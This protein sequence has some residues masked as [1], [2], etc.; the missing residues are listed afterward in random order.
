MI[1]A[2][3]RL[4]YALVAVLLMITACTQQPHP[5]QPKIPQPSGA[6]PPVTAGSTARPVEPV[7]S[8]RPPGM[9]DPPSGHGMS[10][11]TGQKIN[12]R[13]CATHGDR[14]KQ[15]A[16]VLVPLDYAHP[17]GTAITLAI[18][19]TPSTAAH[20]EGSIF[21]NPGGPG[22]SGVD[23]LD[24]FD[25]HGLRA[26]FDIVSWDPRGT[27]NSTPVRCF[28]DQQMDD[29]IGIDYSPDTPREVQR[30]IN[31]N[32]AFGQAC[33]AKSGALLEHL[34]T[35]DT[36]RDLDLLRRLLG[37]PRMNY[38]GFSYGTT[39]GAMY[40]TMYGDRV[41]RM[42]LDGATDVGST[43]TVSQAD[44][45]DRTLG[46]FATW[47]AQ[48]DCR[49]G[50]SKQKVL[51]TVG[52]FLQQLDQHPIAAGQRQLSQ[53]L[54]TSGLLY[55]LYAPASSWP[56]LLKGL[57]LAIYAHNGSVLLSWAYAYYERDGSGHFDQFNAAFPAILCADEP[58][59]GA[60]AELKAWAADEQR[61]R[62]LGQLIGPDLTCATWP[63]KS[64]NDTQHK[65]S[66]SGQTP[67][68][69]LGTT[70]D[71]ATPYEYA[72]HMHDALTSSR[73]ITLDADG[74]LAF[75]QSR[76]VQTKVIDYFDSATVPASSTCPN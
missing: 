1:S 7:P 16:T 6:R 19:R 57:E 38:F 24:Y 40:A 23:F 37:E 2:R 39:I 17:N 75:D 42:V 60:A 26:R 27:G 56:Q 11:Y 5:P 18:A 76:C 36:V 28:T 25:D 31:L 72:Q 59:T 35:A 47:C 63:V 8:V 66:Y 62:T 33:L 64:S 44:G 22:A 13:A 20:P 71:P 54:A 52:S 53:A 61:A 32:T 48:Q 29:L 68:V 34:S 70:G 14:T 15:C 65:I 30:L 74:H 58:N 9:V 49:L 43:P 69:I 21:T 46:N 4:A 50:S 10:R 51:T 12:W 55:A 41:G 3:T 45:F 73:L 67:V